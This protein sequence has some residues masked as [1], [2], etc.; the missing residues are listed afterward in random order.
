MDC[1][2]RSPLVIVHWREW[3]RKWDISLRVNPLAVVALVVS[4][5]VVSMISVLGMSLHIVKTY[6]SSKLYGEG[7]P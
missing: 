3:N 6:A 5:Y 1:E 7:W 2:V 4:V